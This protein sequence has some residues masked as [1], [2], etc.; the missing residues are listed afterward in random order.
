MCVGDQR[1][2][3]SKGTVGKMRSRVFQ[4][5]N[6]WLNQTSRSKDTYS[7]NGKGSQCMSLSLGKDRRNSKS[8]GMVGKMRSR[9]FQNFNRWLNQTSRSKDTARM[10]GGLSDQPNSKSTGMVGKVQSR[11]R[12]NSK[13][14]GTIGMRRSRA[15]Q[16]CNRWLNLSA[17]AKV[18]GSK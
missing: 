8:T 5:F 9:A 10:A 17:T 15:F 6:R 14:K 7:H 1:N 4:N 11:D 13:S 3:K 12:R 16:N 2:S 18:T